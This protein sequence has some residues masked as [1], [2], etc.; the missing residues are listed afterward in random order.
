[1]NQPRILNKLQHFYERGIFFC[2]WLQLVG[3]EYPLLVGAHRLIL[4]LYDNVKVLGSRNC[5]HTSANLGGL[6]ARVREGYGIVEIVNLML[7]ESIN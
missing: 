7:W 1:M 6:D 5:G 4:S 3:N 2:R